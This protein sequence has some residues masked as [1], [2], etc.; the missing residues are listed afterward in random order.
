M[1][2]LLGICLIGGPWEYYDASDIF[3]WEGSRVV[4]V[5]TGTNYCTLEMVT[6]AKTDLIIILFEIN[7]WISQKK[8]QPFDEAQAK[9]LVEEVTFTG[10][11]MAATDVSTYKCCGLL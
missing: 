3:G 11:K 5:T 1:F 10:T 6:R 2:I 8:R 4:A 7:I 9:G